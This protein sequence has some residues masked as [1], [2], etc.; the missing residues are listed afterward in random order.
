[1]GTMKNL[2]FLLSLFISFSLSA[3]VTLPENMY[4]DTAFA[5]YYWGVAS[6]DPL[7]DGVV[8]WTKVAGIP[9]PV[10]QAQTWEIS[11]EQSFATIISTGSV[12]A[13]ATNDL[14]VRAEVSGLQPNTTYYYRFTDSESGQTSQ[15]GRTK[16]APIG[17]VEEMTLAVASCS[18]IYSGFFNAYRN[19]A[20]NDEV[21][22]MIHLGDYIYD[23]VDSEEQIRVPDPFPETPE[24]LQQWRDR[25]AY[26]LLDPDLRLA[27]QMHPWVVIWDNH[28]F[29]DGTEGGGQAFWEYI[30][31]RDYHNDIE[32][33]HRSYSFGNLLD[34]IMI[35]IE[36][37]RN[38]DEV[39]PGESSVLSN[40]Q[41][42]WFL[43]ELGNSEAKWRIV[44]NQKMFGG[45]YSEGIPLWLPIPNA[46]GVFDDGSWDGFMA[47]R[48]TV[49]QFV[50]ENEI[51]NFM[52]ISG[53]V[54][55]S[56]FMD[57]S[58]EPRNE[59]VYDGASGDGALGVEFIPASISRGNFDESG[60]A[61][62]IANIAAD[63]SGG[64]NPHH[65]FTNFID[66]GY[67]IVKIT[68]DTL[69]AQ[70]RYSNKLELTDDEEIG[71]E[72]LMLDGENHW[73]RPSQEPSSIREQKKNDSMLVFPNPA[74][75]TLNVRFK[76]IPEANYLLEVLDTQGR[77]VLSSSST[78][79]KQLTISVSELTLGAYVLQASNE[80]KLFK[81]SFIISR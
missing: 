4:G 56:F 19:I 72:M 9:N 33:I 37:F 31:R 76:D 34:L 39:A 2:S 75:E 64:I 3:Q 60:I 49:L 46:G 54:H 57:L 30:P 59:F 66:H 74:N 62:P 52:V 78:N 20:N 69:T 47:E 68:P 79:Q 80:E 51:D 28:D 61:E 38:M 55:M 8:I 81:K 45:W 63:L 35:D 70:I 22:L 73:H 36:K 44:G 25:H 48:D 15:V 7:H 1:M 43:Q 32:R 53:D 17:N 50:E 27:R 14:C 5:P 67:G 16:T 26:Y 6:G 77:I 24:N 40:D 12:D 65:Q 29:G 42:D 21:D 10:I 11:E 71:M 13:L 18:S 41:R 23:F 58:R